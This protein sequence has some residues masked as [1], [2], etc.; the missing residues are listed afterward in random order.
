MGPLVLYCFF[1]DCFFLLGFSA[2]VPNP[3]ASSSLIFSNFSWF[4]VLGFCSGSRSSNKKRYARCDHLSCTAFLVIVFSCSDSA[5]GCP[6]PLLPRHSFFQ[7][8]LVFGV[9]FC[10]GSRSSDRVDEEL[11]ICVG[12]LLESSSFVET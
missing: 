9:D 3:F 12:I 1:G 4:F 2:G 7:I 11:L 6:I 5:P 10:S 8:F